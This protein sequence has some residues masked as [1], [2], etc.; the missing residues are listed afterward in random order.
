MFFPQKS[1]LFLFLN[2]L[3]PQ[4][5]FLSRNRV[6]RCITRVDRMFG[7]GCG[8][9]KGSKK[10]GQKGVLWGIGP[11]GEGGRIEIKFLPCV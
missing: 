5:H 9:V 2:F 3:T 4:R 7:L 11:L 8:L 10:K 6:Q 1:I